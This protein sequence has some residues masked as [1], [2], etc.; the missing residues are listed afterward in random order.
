MN[1]PVQPLAAASGPGRAVAAW[2]Q[3]SHP[4]VQAAKLRL[5]PASFR[6]HFQVRGRSAEI[7]ETEQAATAR[8]DVGKADHL[9]PPAWPHLDRLAQAFHFTAR[10]F[11]ESGPQMR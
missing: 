2:H 10:P 11:D 5:I 4:R 1:A 8:D 6:S 3:A 9:F 7:G